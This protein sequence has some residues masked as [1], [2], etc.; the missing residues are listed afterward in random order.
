M[1]S[2]LSPRWLDPEQDRA[3]R[4]WLLMSDLLRSQVV[5]DLQVET[6]LS[7]ADFAVLVHLS[8]AT[9]SRMRMTDLACALRWSKSRLS[10]QFS[11]M[12]ARG[13]V[14]RE[15]CP[16][17]ARLTY[18]ELT[19]CGRAEIRRA[20]PIHVESVR[21]HFIDLLDKDQLAALSDIGEI[22]SGHLL[23]I[24]TPSEDGAPPCPTLPFMAE[25]DDCQEAGTLAV[26]PGAGGPG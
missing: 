1:A 23:A 10:H 8:E 12:E 24:G 6:G 15:G 22:V 26:A 20:A 4:T 25:E 9:G 7:N 13:L 14:V 11:R 18:A 2:S 3:W 21:R 17:D 19:A 5:H 16:S